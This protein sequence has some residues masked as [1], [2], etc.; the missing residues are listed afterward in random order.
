[1]KSLYDRIAALIEEILEAIVVCLGLG[2]ALFCGYALSLH[3]TWQDAAAI[4][5]A[6][7][8]LLR[9]VRRRGNP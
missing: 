2:M 8:L 5:C 1:M 6:G 7:L 9:A 3:M 4:V